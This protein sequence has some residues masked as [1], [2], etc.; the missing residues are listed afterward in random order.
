M[1]REKKSA[2][3][4]QHEMGLRGQ[5][6]LV[7]RETVSEK[8]KVTAA[9]TLARGTGKA[10]LHTNLEIQLR[11]QSTFVD[12]KRE[13]VAATLNCYWKKERSATT[14]LEQLASSSRCGPAPRDNLPVPFPSYV[15]HGTIA[16]QIRTTHISHCDYSGHH[17]FY[18][19]TS[20][21]FGPAGSPPRLLRSARRQ[22]RGFTAGYKQNPSY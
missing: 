15:L 2:R 8:A 20:C 22:L 16:V 21:A 6:F 13:V 11:R 9:R 3:D 4:V 10:L 14:A 19:Y 18:H 17:A 12:T 5:P 1:L 7:V